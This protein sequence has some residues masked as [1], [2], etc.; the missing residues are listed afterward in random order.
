MEYKIIITDVC[1]MTCSYCYQGIDK[2]INRINSVEAKIITESIYRHIKYKDE[3]IKVNFFGGEPLLNFSVMNEIV[4]YLNEYN[5]DI[6]YSITTNALLIDDNIINFF[7]ENN[8]LVRISIDGDKDTMELNRKCGIENY[9]EVIERSIKKLL[10]NKINIVA[11]MTVTANNIMHLSNNVK[12]ID[13]LGI[14]NICA[15]IDYGSEF[16]NDYISIFKKE[17]QKLEELYLKNFYEN[18]E[19]N[20][21]IVN[22]KMLKYASKSEDG[23]KLC[24]AGSTHYVIGADAKIYP[25]TFVKDSEKFCIGD[26]YDLSKIK[27]LDDEIAEKFDLEDSDCNNCKISYACHGMK[28]GYM[29][30]LNTGSFNRPSKIMCSTEKLLYEFNCRILKELMK[31]DYMRTDLLKYISNNKLEKSEVLENILNDIGEI[32]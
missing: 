26:I 17:L 7:K 29:N 9:F 20:L 15:G 24:G 32:V 1:N 5:L 31:N 28:C 14:K 30:L 25:C 12:Y 3:T 2:K 13:S 4:D 23:V 10:D 21:D 11:R 6:N 8:F 16:S 19:F 18:R 22:G 27:T